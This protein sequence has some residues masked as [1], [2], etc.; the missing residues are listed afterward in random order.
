MKKISAKDIVNKTDDYTKDQFED[1]LQMMLDKYYNL[2]MLETDRA[3]EE[4]SNWDWSINKESLSDF[5]EVCSTYARFIGYQNRII[6][7]LD[8]VN[9]HETILEFIIKNAKEIASQ[10]FVGTAKTKDAKTSTMLIDISL[11]HTTICALSAFLKSSQKAIEFNTQQ[12]ARILRER[13]AIA[14]INGPAYN[15]G[16]AKKLSG[17]IQ[18]RTRNK[19]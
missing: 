5:E 11:E 10:F 18:V 9:I 12:L 1:D 3:R 2:P 19:Y 16:A 13:E 14:R 4:V 8:D 15:T 7:L 17:E 6:Q